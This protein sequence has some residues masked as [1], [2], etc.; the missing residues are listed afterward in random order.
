MFLLLFVL[1]FG[2]FASPLPGLPSPSSERAVENRAA[3]TQEETRSQSTSLQG[4]WQQLNHWILLQQRQLHRQLADQV[5]R[6][7]DE[8]SWQTAQAL[9]WL[10]FLYGV[11]HAAGP[12]HGKA[13]LTT[14]LLTHPAQ[15]KKG[16]FLSVVA[17]LLQGVTAILL[18]TFLVLVLGWLAR[19]AFSQVV[20]VEM[21]SFALV[22]LVGIYLLGRA[23]RRSWALYRAHRSSQQAA[24]TFQF[25][26]VAAS[27]LQ[28]PQARA[29]GGVCPSCGKVHHVSPADV[30]DRTPWQ[31]AGLLL[32][33]GLRPCS[34]AVLVLAVAHLLGMWWIGI[35]SAMA[36]AVGTALTVSVLAVLAV[37]VRDLAQGLT[38]LQGQWLSW[39]SLGLGA[40]GGLIIFFLGVSLLLGSW[41][42]Q[43]PLI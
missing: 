20:Y 13:V 2:L 29:G 1:S 17:A 8:L 27:P 16:L 23:L 21:L 6:F 34:G 24:V 11:F 31:T 42:N 22:A 12:G 41:Q 43:H 9:L 38:R 10:S 19:E 18:V 36:M 15:L 35:G 28:P 32:A 7:S 30:E 40:L 5:E 25:Q 39:V 33:I 4:Y 26:P 37:K 3:P 14:Y